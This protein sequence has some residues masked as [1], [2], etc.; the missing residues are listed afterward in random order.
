MI[1]KRRL[2]SGPGESDYYTVVQADFLP[3]KPQ[4]AVMLLAQLGMQY[5]FFLMLWLFEPRQSLPTVLVAYAIALGLQ[6]ADWAIR[7]RPFKALTNLAMCNTVMLFY[8]V[9]W[10][11]L[12]YLLIL[13]GLA[14]LSRTFIL[15]DQGRHRYNPGTFGVFI[16]GLMASEV[17]GVGQFVL[18]ISHGFTAIPHFTVVVIVLGT[19]MASLGGH[20][21]I[22]LSLMAGFYLT[23]GYPNSPE[24]IVFFFA[25]TDPVT[26]PKKLWT[27]WV[28]GLTAGALTG[29]LWQF[30]ANELA[31]VA[32]LI[33]TATLMPSLRRVDYDA[34]AQKAL[35]RLASESFWGQKGWRLAGVAILVVFA[36]QANWRYPFHRYQFSFR[37][38]DAEGAPLPPAVYDELFPEGVVFAYKDMAIEVFWANLHG[39]YSGK[40]NKR[41]NSPIDETTPVE[42]RYHLSCREGT[43]PD[44]VILP[45]QRE[46][47]TGK[48]LLNSQHLY[49]FT[50]PVDVDAAR[51]ACR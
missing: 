39:A 8:R 19:A 9:H 17:L 44:E 31:K 35:G 11:E 45:I 47:K 14:W 28:F 1:S 15:N 22:V 40:M 4:A 26:T 41:V 37:V 43:G 50:I 5:F 29:F 48:G 25:A 49:T 3:G 10:R 23:R 36:F 34:Y 27:R 18:P 12:E 21:A 7:R 20:L 6:G 30:T 51:R 42:V 46:R 33:L 38:S 13:I 2:T 24:L 16:G 32:G